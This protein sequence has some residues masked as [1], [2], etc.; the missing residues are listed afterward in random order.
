M[1]LFPPQCPGDPA[2]PPP[3][4]ATTRCP[5]HRRGRGRRRLRRA[6]HACRPVPVRR[7]RTRRR[8]PLDALGHGVFGGRVPGVRAGQRYGFRAHGPWEP[9]AGHR[10]NPAKLL[11]DPYARG[12]DGDVAHTPETYGHLVGPDLAGDPYGP[13]DPRDS[14]GHVPWSVVVDTRDLPGPDPAAN[15]PWTPWSRTVV[16]EAHVR[17]LTQLDDRMP[18]ELRGTYA[19][20]A[21][22]AV[23]D[24]LLGLGVTAIELLPV[25]AFSSEPHLV[26]KGL[27]NYWGYSTLGFFAPH[28]AFATA[29]AQSAGPAAVLAELRDRGPH[30]ARGRPRG[31]ARRRLQP[32]LRGRA[33]RSAPVLARSGQRHLLRAR[34]RRARRARGRHGHREH[35]R[36]PAGRGGPDDPGL[37]ALL[38][39]RRGRRRVPLRPGGDARPRPGR[40]LPRPPR[41]RRD[42]D[43][44]VAARAQARRGAVGRRPRRL[45]HR[46]VPRPVRRVERPLPQRRPL[47]LARR[48]RPRRARPARPPR[49][50]P[51]HPPVRIRRPVR[52]QR[53]A[54]G[55]GARA[56]RSTT[57]PPTTASRSRTWWPTTTSTTRP[58]GSRTATAATTTARGTTG[59]RA[60][61]APTPP[62]ST[63]CPCVAARSATCS[64]PSCS[65]RA[66]R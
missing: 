32:H 23:V 7:R 13:A 49:P 59:S 15:R 64:P 5:R 45:A 37:A 54:A 16:Y 2:L 29:A 30:A 48:P 35:A 4:T 1:G 62:R 56:R 6:R 38:G 8:V 11:V 26:E 51:G 52:P 34:R 33:A 50:R 27:T 39:G 58:T 42:G 46:A 60:T 65:R 21:H 19:G 24:H 61:S 53:P 47:V 41:A 3:A 17:G 57:S 10:Y 14:A 44:A 25:H 28:A 12:L 9:A 20:L 55:P 36:L 22:P 66:P 63:S 43:R 18:P 31:A 40:L